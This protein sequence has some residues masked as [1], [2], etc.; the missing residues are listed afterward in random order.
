[1]LC[2]YRVKH[3][4]KAGIVLL[5]ALQIGTRRSQSHFCH[6][7]RLGKFDT[8]RTSV[9]RGVP[10][11]RIPGSKEMTHSRKRKPREY[12]YLTQRLGLAMQSTEGYAIGSK[13][14]S[15]TSTSRAFFE[16]D[17]IYTGFKHT[18]TLNLEL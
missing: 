12:S 1:M 4:V 6:Q 7:A 9:A 14:T 16:V 3:I 5:Y 10:K 8:R 2:Q 18:V 17:L 13:E 15:P 11:W